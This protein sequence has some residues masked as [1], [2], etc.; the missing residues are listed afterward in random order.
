MKSLVIFLGGVV[1]E[2][3]EAAMDVTSNEDWDYFCSGLH[4]KL[5]GEIDYEYDSFLE[6]RVLLRAVLSKIK[7]DYGDE[8]LDHMHSTYHSSNG[9]DIGHEIA[10]VP[11]TSSNSML[12][13][14]KSF[15]IDECDI[16]SL[17]EF[18]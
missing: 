8:V 4:G 17:D 2:Y 9:L 7:R 3:I 5:I 13:V 1:T 15:V 16:R 12:L 6:D 14:S 10:L 11:E 18:I